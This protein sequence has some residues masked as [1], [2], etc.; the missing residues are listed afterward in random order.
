MPPKLH[1]TKTWDGGSPPSD[2]AHL[3]R[4]RDGNGHFLELPD[5]VVDK[6]PLSKDE[7]AGLIS[8]RLRN[9]KTKPSDFLKLA[10]ALKTLLFPTVHLVRRK[11]RGKSHKKKIVIAEPPKPARTVDDLVREIESERIKKKE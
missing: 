11:P 5:S 6:Q 7:L 8:A 9:P 10:S 3:K 2:W 4:E 1:W